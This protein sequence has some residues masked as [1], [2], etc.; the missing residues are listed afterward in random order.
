MNGSYVDDA[1]ERGRCL[2]A[3]AL[4]NAVLCAA[5]DVVSDSPQTP[6]WSAG[7]ARYLTSLVCLAATFRRIVRPWF[8]QRQWKCGTKLC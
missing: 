3:I 2:N 5:C 7:A 8:P 1:P 4:Q 6:A